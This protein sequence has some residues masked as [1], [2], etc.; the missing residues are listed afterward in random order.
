[1]EAV[2]QVPQGSKERLDSLRL[3]L[4]AAAAA[5]FLGCVGTVE[6]AGPAPAG[7][8]GGGRG[9]RAEQAP[10]FS[11]NP[12]AISPSQEWK[13][14]SS[15]QYRNT[16]RDLITFALG[17]AAAA[18]S[19]I[20]SLGLSRLP[21][22][23]LGLR[24]S[25]SRASQ[26]VTQDHIAAWYQTA[27]AVGR[28]LS[29][30]ARLKTVLGACAGDIN[31][32]NDAACLT[33]FIKRFGE[34]ALR[35]PLAPDEVATFAAFHGAPAGVT[36]DGLT[37]VIS[38]ILLAPEFVYQVEHGET[39]VAGKDQVFS[40]TAFELASRLS[41][42]FWDTFPDSELW[43][44]AK[45]GALRSAAGYERQVDRLIRDPRARQMSETFFR[46]W[47]ALDEIPALDA[48]T[49][50]P[51]FKAFA[52]KDLPKGKL[53]ESLID[54]VSR[55]FAYYVW[56]K[57]GGLEDLL[58]SRLAFAESP[59]V[60]QL[61]GIAPWQ[62]GSPPSFAGTERS[63]FLTRAAFLVSGGANTRPIHRGVFIRKNILC[64]E[65][66]TPGG[67]VP[68]PP[69]LSDR[70]T[71]REAVET[72]TEGEGTSCAGCHKTLINPVGFA[73]EGFDALGRVRTDQPLYAQDGREIA[74]R[75]VDQSSV[76]Q[77]VAGDAR[78]ANGA[79][80]LVRFIVESRKV[81][82][83][84]A[85][86]YFQF[87]YGRKADPDLDGCVLESM[88]KK[89]ADNGEISGALR[90]AVLDPEFQQRSFK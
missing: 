8:G 89:W 45:T 43:D 50:L 35:R 73:L 76:P 61:Y 14:L 16:I 72:L 68:P 15:L 42:H 11:C 17:D 18:T 57:S 87:T 34:R 85:R 60:A 37:D 56:N 71:T 41:Y 51:V 4:V 88:R 27:T 1:M 24:G 28:L 62:G 63:G 55:M 64:D 54:E 3:F 82:A 44:A 22:D 31:T 65:L 21:D 52:G 26:D 32:S 74:R 66:P 13:R 20:P 69:E 30:P 25:F 2:S 29:D 7:I 59:D 81:P 86:N 79:A 33:D 47:L 23:A 77:I 36:P 6:D 80:D 9:S 39:A 67:N 12:A 48:Q 5:T 40:L 46:Q 53:R 38:A 83:C 78:V 58:Q 19:V 84:A 10:K 90:A 49:T 70:L 75:P